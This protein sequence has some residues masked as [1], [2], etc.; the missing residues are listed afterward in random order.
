MALHKLSLEKLLRQLPQEKQS[1]YRAW[2][3]QVLREAMDA[4]LTKRQREVLDCY[5][6]RGW[7]L[8]RIAQELHRNPSTIC[9]TKQR[10]L[11]RLEVYLSILPKQ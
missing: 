2:L 10:A 7:N 1:S 3:N 11:R 9:R 4:V 8:V 6:Q 5:Y